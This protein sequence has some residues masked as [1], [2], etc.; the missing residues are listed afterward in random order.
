MGPIS[1]FPGLAQWPLRQIR[2]PAVLY[3]C[4]KSTAVSAFYYTSSSVITH[5]CTS[6]ILTEFQREDVQASEMSH[7]CNLVFHGPDFLRLSLTSYRLCYSCVQ[8][9]PGWWAATTSVSHYKNNSFKPSSLV[10]LWLYPSSALTDLLII[11]WFR[12]FRVKWQ[13]FYICSS[14]PCHEEG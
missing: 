1:I 4:S 6:Q 14:W 11:P 10:I 9:A 13:L 2:G 7:D 5:W 12:C 8:E 3:I